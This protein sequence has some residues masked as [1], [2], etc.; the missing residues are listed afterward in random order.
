VDY[1]EFFVLRNKAGKAMPNMKYKIKTE[2][3]KIIEG[4]TDAE[5][6]TD[7]VTSLAMTKAKVTLLG[8]VDD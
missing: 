8:Y 5:G 7:L 2:N 3:G 6:K 1:D 4:I